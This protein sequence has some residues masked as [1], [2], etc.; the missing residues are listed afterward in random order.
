MF[1]L[2]GDYT[3]AFVV[4]AGFSFVSICT[5]WAA[6]FIGKARRVRLRQT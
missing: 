5:A 3:Q 1:D 2:Q 6:H 4:S